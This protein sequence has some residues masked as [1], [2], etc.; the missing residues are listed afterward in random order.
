MCVCVVAVSKVF[1]CLP[2]PEAWDKADH[3]EGVALLPNSLFD[4]FFVNYIRFW[5][6]LSSWKSSLGHQHFRRALSSACNVLGAGWNAND[7]S[8]YIFFLNI[9]NA[10]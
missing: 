9:Q 6:T 8:Y 5:N 4:L 10:K 2:S 7:L 3:E 1:S